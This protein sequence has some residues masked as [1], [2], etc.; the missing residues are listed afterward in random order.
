MICEGGE[1]PCDREEPGKVTMGSCREKPLN[2]PIGISQDFLEKIALPTAQ[3][4]SCI[5]LGIPAPSASLKCLY[6]SA[7]NMGN[8]QEELKICVQ[9][10]SHDIVVI[11]ETCQDSSHDWI[12]V[13][14]GYVLFRKDRAVRRGGF[15]LCKRAPRKY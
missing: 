14:S 6:T 12:A 15:S 7:Y 8:K 5:P 11:T 2:Y 13:V 1:V 10:K 9:S 3:L 4:K